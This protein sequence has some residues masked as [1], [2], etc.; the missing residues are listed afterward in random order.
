MDSN[1]SPVS[2]SYK[3]K[4]VGRPGYVLSTTNMNNALKYM[5]ALRMD[6]YKT[7]LYMQQT[8]KDGRRTIH[9]YL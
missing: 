2:I 5:Q 9:P 4:I 8:E 6:G 3:V 7:E 1:S